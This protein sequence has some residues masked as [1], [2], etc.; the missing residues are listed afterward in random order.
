KMTLTLGSASSPFINIRG[1]KSQGHFHHWCMKCS[2]RNQLVP[3]KKL[4]HQPLLKEISS[5][6][7]NQLLCRVAF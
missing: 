3:V 5:K 2:L 6:D 1:A 7:E 4:L